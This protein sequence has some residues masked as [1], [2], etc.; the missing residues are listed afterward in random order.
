MS[1]GKP[2]TGKRYNEDYAAD[3]DLDELDDH[4]EDPDTD[5]AF[6]NGR[7]F[8]NK[9]DP[10]DSMYLDSMNDGDMGSLIDDPETPAD[11]RMAAIARIRYKYLGL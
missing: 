4:D 11:V 3:D 7:P 8:V 1:F 10:S 6:L 5:F 2:S 9:D